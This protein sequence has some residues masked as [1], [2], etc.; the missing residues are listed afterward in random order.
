VFLVSEISWG[1]G[2]V[3]RHLSIGGDNDKVIIASDWRSILVGKYSGWVSKLQKNIHSGRNQKN[4]GEQ[5]F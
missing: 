3:E 4:N 5:Q 2:E 1:R